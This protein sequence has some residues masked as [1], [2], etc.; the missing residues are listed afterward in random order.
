M[1]ALRI[2]IVDLDTSHPNGWVPIIK[3]LGHR[4][5]AVFDGGT[6][7]EEG[8]ASRFAEK[9][10]IGVV[11]ESLEEMARLVDAAIIHSVNWDLHVERARPFVEAGKAV[12]IDK[13]MA[14]SMHDIR[15]LL[16]WERGG[17]RITGGS[18]LSVCEEAVEWHRQHD[19]NDPIVTVLAGCSVDEF[20]YGIHAFY[21]LQAI[22]GPGIESVRSAG[23]HLQHQIELRWQ[24]GRKGFL[25]VGATQGYLPFYATIVTGHTVKHLQVDSSRLYRAFLKASLPYL[26]GDAEPAVALSR[27]LEAELAAAA[28]RKSMSLGGLQVALT[29]LSDED[30]GYDGA[31]FAAQYRMKAKGQ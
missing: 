7:H 17:A 21:F 25:S 18:S 2:G 12:M 1:Q 23:A 6:V 11:C 19:P 5:V 30:Q 29:E 4:V 31:A 15:Q 9:H 13:P 26:A 3:E 27:L 22:M 8:Y 24:D 16:E 20:N 10:D 28:A 14:G